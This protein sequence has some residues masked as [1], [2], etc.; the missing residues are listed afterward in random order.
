MVRVAGDRAQREATK[1]N[2]GVRLHVGR[3]VTPLVSLNG[4]LRYQRW[5]SGPFAVEVDPSGASVDVLS[6]AIG[7]RFHVKLGG[8]WLR[9][10]LA[11][12]RALDKPLA[13]AT[14]NLHT[15]QL[16]VPL[17]F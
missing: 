15:V 5:L 6:A 8:L 7:P 4:E 9:P 13:A 10:G 14:P 3:F 1:T 11:Y 12:V 17:F 16:D 2:S